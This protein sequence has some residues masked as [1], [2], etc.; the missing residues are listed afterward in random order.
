MATAGKP[1]T[2]WGGIRPQLA[3]RR[4]ICSPHRR[5]TP[6]AGAGVFLG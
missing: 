4:A 5:T 1:T 3:Q 2:T 6:I